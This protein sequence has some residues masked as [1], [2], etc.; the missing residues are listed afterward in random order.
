MLNEISYL[1]PRKDRISLRGE[2]T[3]PAANQLNCSLAAILAITITTGRP[4]KIATG[5]PFQQKKS[6]RVENRY[7][8]KKLGQKRSLK[9]ETED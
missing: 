6:A 8:Y 9:N 3:G 7:R 1:L 5:I 4:K 2:L